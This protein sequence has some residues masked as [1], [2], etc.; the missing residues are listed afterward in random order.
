MRF[1]FIFCQ[2]FGIFDCLSKW[3]L[4]NH[5]IMA[6]YKEKPCS[7]FPKPIFRMITNM[8]PK[9]RFRVPDSSL[10]IYIFDECIRLFF[11]KKFAIFACFQRCE[12]LWF[13]KKNKST[14]KCIFSD[15]HK[16]CQDIFWKLW[17]S[18][19]FFFLVLR[20]TWKNRENTIWNYCGRIRITQSYG[21]VSVIYC[22]HFHLIWKNYPLYWLNYDFDSKSWK[23]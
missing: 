5:Q 6:K 3:S 15:N 4:K 23:L 11:L 22:L 8:Y 2:I 17:D 16:K 12:L 9:I 13:G 20:M 19:F 1:F 7:T 18:R 10:V 21:K 14:S